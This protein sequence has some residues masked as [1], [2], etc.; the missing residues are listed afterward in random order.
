MTSDEL[1]KYDELIES[2]PDGYQDPAIK[3]RDLDPETNP[4]QHVLGFGKHQGMTLDEVASID[5]GLG[6]LGYYFY[7]ITATAKPRDIPRIGRF[8]E[9]V[10]ARME[11]SR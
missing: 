11:G 4:G 10:W 5:G 1:R 2:D 9:Q 8:L 7:N 3:A 6:T